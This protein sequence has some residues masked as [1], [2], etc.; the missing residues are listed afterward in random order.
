VVLLR[1]FPVIATLLYEVSMYLLH[2]LR[3][4]RGRAGQGR[5]YGGYLAGEGKV[6][7]SPRTE[8]ISY[9]VAC[10]YTWVYLRN[11]GDESDR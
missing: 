3:T 2:A 5:N 10:I 6:E 8:G 9:L 1:G 7:L 4:G 11:G